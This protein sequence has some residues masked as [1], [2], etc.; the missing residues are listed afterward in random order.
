MVLTRPGAIRTNFLEFATQ[1]FAHVRLGQFLTKLELF[2]AF[3]SGQMQARVLSQFFGAGFAPFFHYHIG[4]HHFPTGFGTAGATTH[5][6][7]SR[8]LCQNRL[9]FIG[10]DI[11]AGDQN[12]ILLAIDNAKLAVGIHARNIAGFQPAVVR[13]CQRAFAGLTPI[14]Q[15]HLR[16]AYP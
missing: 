11:K 8:M 3:I 5:F 12:H 16:P 15:H 6:Q 9:H 4:F 1:D 2:R 13:F 7:Y 14:A 10:I